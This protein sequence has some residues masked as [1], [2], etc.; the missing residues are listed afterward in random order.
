MQHTRF[1]VVASCCCLLLCCLSLTRTPQRKRCAFCTFSHFSQAATAT[2]T[3]NSDNFI[4][5]SQTGVVVE[6]K[7]RTRIH[8][9]IRCC[10][11]SLSHNRIALPSWPNSSSR[12]SP[13]GHK[14]GDG[15]FVKTSL[16]LAFWQQRRL[17]PSGSRPRTVVTS[18][19]KVLRANSSFSLLTRSRGCQ[20][21]DRI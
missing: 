21:S 12:L 13:F 8:L 16:H 1:D 2:Q 10:S 20:K 14:L 17:T 18:L 15:A 11:R 7:S 3:H 5:L 6:Q 4:H 19:T 9:R